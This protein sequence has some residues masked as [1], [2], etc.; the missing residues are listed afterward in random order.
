[1]TQGPPD[2]DGPASADGTTGAVG[3]LSRTLRH[4]AIIS[5]GTFAVLQI[6]A[7]AQIVV[8]ARL[9]TPAEIGLFAA[10]TVLTGFLV[11][12]SADGLAVAL[13][14]RDGSDVRDAADTVFWAS[15]GTGLL[16]SAAALACAPLIGVVFDSDAAGTVAAVTSGV[17]LLHSLTVVPDALMQ[18]RFDFRRRM[19]VNPS[20]AITN[21]GVAIGLAVAG[22]GVWALVI[23]NYASYA[24]WVLVT[25]SLGRWRPGLGRPSVRL[26]RELARFSAPLVLNGT[27]WRLREVIETALVGRRLDEGA[28]G[29]YRYGRRLAML[30]GTAVVEIGAYVLLPAFA[31]IAGDPER[32][33]TG[34]RRAL[35]AVWTV[36]A[37]LAAVLVALGE[38][39]VVTLLGSQW[40]EAGIA[41][42]AMA[43]FGLGEGLGAVSDE[44]VKGSG[45]SHLLHWTTAVSLVS[46]VVLLVVLLPYGLLGV[47]LAI[48]GANLAMGLTA[49]VVAGHVTGTPVRTVLGGL[50]PA[51]VAGVVAVVAVGA[52]EHLVVHADTMAL[53]LA[54]LTLVGEMLLVGAVFA[55]VLRLVAPALT[56]ELTTSLRR[57]AGA[58][59]A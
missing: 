31:R 17:T 50:V 58:R 45:R 26:W 13:I 44:A 16:L 2:P 18:R 8:L 28:V 11:S 30:P 24:V 22:Y 34:F 14:Q 41:L 42:A 52:L 23:A 40:R 46:T 20:V 5:A 51:L 49:V 19:I 33:R 7:F 10:G 35:A 39:L 38:P 21:A 36:S 43:G 59:A 4:G 47:G 37:V 54:L 32:F 29:Q 48:S 6:V 55:A 15:L 9:L 57:F 56:A 27:A 25:W 1:M 53:P 12:T 3:S